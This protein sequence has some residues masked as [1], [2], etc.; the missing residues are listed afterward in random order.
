LLG[1]CHIFIWTRQITANSNS[2]N[3]R[4]VCSGGYLKSKNNIN[5][6]KYLVFR[7]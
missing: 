6:S 5:W 3:K 7:L 2:W 4:Q 1:G